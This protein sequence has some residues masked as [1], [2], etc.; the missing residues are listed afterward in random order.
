MTS[1]GLAEAQTE[2]AQFLRQRRAAHRVDTQLRAR[3]EHPLHA[4]TVQLVDLSLSGARL[5][6]AL[7]CAVGS[8]LSLVVELSGGDVPLACEVVWIANDQTGVRFRQ[9]S[10]VDAGALRDALMRAELRNLL[11]RT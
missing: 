9:L 11:G 1:E 5:D 4:T 6:R 7:Q 3:V 8:V 2:Q 10:P